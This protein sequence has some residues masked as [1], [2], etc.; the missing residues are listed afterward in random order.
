VSVQPRAGGWR[1]R[2]TEGARHRSRQ[3]ARKRDAVAFDS[4][5]KRRQRLGPLA[6]D[7]DAGAETLDEFVVERWLPAH[8]ALLAPRTQRAYANVYDHHIA[9]ALGHVPLREITPATVAQWQAARLASGAGPHAVAKATALLGGILQRAVEHGRIPAN[10]ARVVRKAR[11][12]RRAEVRPLAPI[13][14]ERLRAAA[15]PRTAMLV[16][17]VA[18]AGLRPSEALALQWRDVREHTL[19]VERALDGADGS[20]APKGWRARAVRL[21]APL[22]QDLRE[23][24]L[25]SGRPDGRAPVIPAR[26]GGTWSEQCYRSWRR[27]AFARAAAAAGAHGARPYDLR[28]SYASLLLHEG[29]SVVYVARQM[30]HDATMT[31]L[32]YGHALD[33]LENQPRVDAA[34]A[35]AQARATL[36]Q[37]IAS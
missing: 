7:L 20:R 3:F 6:I 36:A 30:G 10:P 29:R 14:V 26:N 12:P 19:L 21:L 15:D 11:P 25:A 23:W 22:A 24:R 27:G 2:W 32:V 35:I 33:E 9:P 1:V 28:H 4:E 31:L 5:I 16:S 18:Y 13:T 17:L 37:A 34:Q 8:G